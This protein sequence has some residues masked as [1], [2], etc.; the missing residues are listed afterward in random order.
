[1]REAAKVLR[2]ADSRCHGRI[3][4][5]TPQDL[6][7]TAEAWEAEDN[8]AAQRETMVEE[9]ARDARIA[10]DCARMAI[11]SGWRKVTDE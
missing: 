3:V 2:E 11:E 6:E 8:A 10:P 4:G 1:M 5:W 7:G 9:L